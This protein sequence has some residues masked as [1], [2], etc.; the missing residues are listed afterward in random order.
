MAEDSNTS[1]RVTDSG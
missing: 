1:G